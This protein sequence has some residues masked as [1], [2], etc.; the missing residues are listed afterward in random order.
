MMQV[1]RAARGMIGMML[2]G[3]IALGTTG[4][5][6]DDEPQADPTPA[7]AS[8]SP[9]ASPTPSVDATQAAIDERAAEAEKRYREYWE[10]AAK[11]ATEGESPLDE[12]DVQSYLMGDFAKQEIDHWATFESDDWKEAGEV[13]VVSAMTVEY[14][15]DPLDEDITGHRVH[16]QVCLDTSRWDLL[17]PDGKSIISSEQGRRLMDVVLQGQPKAGVWSI[18]KNERIEGAEC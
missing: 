17:G 14:E 2:A 18:R 9:T 16:L 3:A 7:T 8:P 12:L 4:C 6:S 1:N 11:Y 5:T 15:G 13:D 10:I